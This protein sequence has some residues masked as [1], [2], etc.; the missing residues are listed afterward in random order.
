MTWTDEQVKV[1]AREFQRVWDENIDT[2]DPELHDEDSYIE[3]A[4]RA[5]L[6]A[7]DRPDGSER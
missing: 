5:A 2:F 1:A 6:N 4:M 3:T 7:T